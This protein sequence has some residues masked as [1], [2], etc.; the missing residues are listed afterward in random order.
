M[1]LELAAGQATRL[2]R[3]V[4]FPHSITC[5]LRQSQ[6]SIATTMSCKSTVCLANLLLPHSAA[7]AQARGTQQD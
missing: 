5:W 3:A 1:H 2:A 7:H 4:D 6:I